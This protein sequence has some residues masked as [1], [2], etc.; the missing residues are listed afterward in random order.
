MKCGVILG[1]HGA[2]LKVLWRKGRLALAGLW[3]RAL[4]ARLTLDDGAQRKPCFCF[5][6]N[7]MYLLPPEECKIGSRIFKK[8]RS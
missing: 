3:E 1:G 8:A 5:K 2:Q 6:G 4:A 7:L